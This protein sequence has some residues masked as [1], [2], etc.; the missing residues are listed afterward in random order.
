MIWRTFMLHTSRIL[1]LAFALPI[2]GGALASSAAGLTPVASAN[3]KAVGVAAPNVLSPELAEQI[4]VQGSTPLENP[5]D[6]FTH[7]GY[8]ND[9]PMLPAL[10]SN[11]EATKTEPDKNT[12]LVFRQLSGPDHSYDYGHRFLFQG[13]ENSKGGNSYITRV[14]L[15]ADVEHRVTLLATKDTLG[16]DLPDFDGSTWYPWS[17]RLLFT[18]EGAK[19][20]GVWQATPGYPSTVDSLVGI[21]GQGGYEGIQA[22]SRGNIWIVEDSGGTTGTTFPHARRPNSFIYRF[23]PKDPSDLTKGGKLQALQVQSKAHSGPIAFTPGST[24]AIVDGDI[25]SQ[26]QKDLHTY[27]KSFSTKWITIHDTA[28]DGFAAFNANALAKNAQATPFK[29][30]ENGQFRPGTGFREFFFDTTGDTNALSEAGSFGGFGAVFKLAQRSPSADEGTLTLFYRSDA[31]HSGFDN[32]AFWSAN[33]IVFVQD[34]GDTMH[35]QINAYDSAFMFDVRL[36]YSKPAN[37]PVRILAVGRD[38]SATI[39]AGLSGSSGFQNEGDNEITGIHVSD[40][41]PGVGGLLGAKLPWLFHFG[42]RAF[43]TQQHGDNQT[44]EI[45]PAQQHRHGWGLS[46]DDND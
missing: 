8:N 18:S 30:P 34:M 12:Y 17:E 33:E 16:N 9:G 41:D 21:M 4:V 25:G 42:W 37:Q 1:A 5:A 28:V 22:D 3:P 15:D 43:Y 39:D 31:T 19:G 46:D 6:Q 26:D 36:D 23:I 10:N 7:Y 45:V 11:V 35:S 14:N 29:R 32:V 27:G 2:F 44:F 20:G 38:P 24:P 13:H 40:G